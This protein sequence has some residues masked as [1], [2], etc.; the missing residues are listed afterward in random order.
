MS[1]KTPAPVRTAAVT[2]TGWQAITT[3][4]SAS[5]TG[6]L[7]VN[8]T[9]TACAAGHAV[10]GHGRCRQ[11]DGCANCVRAEDERIRQAVSQRLTE[12]GD[13]VEQALAFASSAHVAFL[14]LTIGYLTD[15]DLA[16]TGAAD[17]AV[18]RLTQILVGLR[19]VARIV[20]NRQLREQLGTL[21]DGQ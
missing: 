5:Q 17:D 14:E 9:T 2:G 7:T 18:A 10:C 13:N 1:S 19:D 3:R 20:E 15:T 16:E 4:R 6:E 21:E 11:C 8:E 12:A